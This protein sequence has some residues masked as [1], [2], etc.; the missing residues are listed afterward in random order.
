MLCGAGLHGSK[1]WRGSTRKRQIWMRSTRGAF[2]KQS[3]PF[4]ASWQDAGG[5][6]VYAT[7]SIRRPDGRSE[8][9]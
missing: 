8:A 2:E 7:L 5:A 3:V 6:K 9:L 1:P 4:W